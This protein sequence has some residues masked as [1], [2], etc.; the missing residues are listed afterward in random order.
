MILSDATRKALADLEAN[1]RKRDAEEE[2]VDRRLNVLKGSN[3]RIGG[4]MSNIKETMKSFRAKLSKVRET[5][6][7][8][9]TGIQFE[10]SSN[11]ELQPPSDMEELAINTKL[12]F[13]FNVSQSNVGDDRAFLCYIGNEEGTHT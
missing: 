4:V 6:K 1:R 9:D 11:L 13:Y 10:Q 3:S 7:A 12:E 2:D 5:I 8:I